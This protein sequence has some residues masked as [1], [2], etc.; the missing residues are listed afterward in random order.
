LIITDQETQKQY[1]ILTHQPRAPTGKI[2]NEIPAGMTDGEG[3]LKGVAIRE[4][5]EEWEEAVPG[6]GKN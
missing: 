6:N 3:N 4:L 2:L 1:T 5:E